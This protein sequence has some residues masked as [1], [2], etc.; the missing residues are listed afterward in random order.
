[1]G[2]EIGP[3]G[4]KEEWTEQFRR[5]ITERLGIATG[6]EPYHDIRF[7][8]MAVVPDKRI[9]LVRQVKLLKANRNI[10]LQSVHKIIESSITAERASLLVSSSNM[11]TGSFT[12]SSGGTDNS[13]SLSSDY[14]N[15]SS[16]DIK[17]L[18]SDMT[19]TSDD[20]FFNE[21]GKIFN[22]LGYKL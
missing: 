20:D 2:I 8:L 7:N 4:D 12:T 11:S 17:K 9:S 13:L 22:E 14:A 19:S 5:V 21:P 18:V 3:W 6:G 10:I 15:L 16:K 1:M